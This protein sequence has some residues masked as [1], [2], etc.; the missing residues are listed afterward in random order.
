MS[1][2][3]VY[4]TE[5]EREEP[6]GQRSGPPPHMDLNTRLLAAL[7]DHV[8][9]EENVS[10]HLTAMHLEAK[11]AMKSASKQDETVV[12][13]TD[14][15]VI[16][17]AS[18][19]M[20]AFHMFT[21]PGYKRRDRITAFATAF[22][23]ILLQILAISAVAVGSMGF[24]A[25]R[26]DSDC[27]FEGMFC[28][29]VGGGLGKICMACW[30]NSDKSPHIPEPEWC[31]I[32][33]ES[34]AESNQQAR[35]IELC[36]LCYDDDLKVIHY[37]T[38]M[39]KNG[40]EQMMLGDWANLVIGAIV[41]GLTVVGEL[42]DILYL[43]CKLETAAA[44]TEGFDLWYPACLML[45]SVRLYIFLPILCCTV[46]W[47]VW[48]AGS[49]ALSIC[50]NTVAVGFLV[51]LD[52]MVF[53]SGLEETTKQ[54][55]TEEGAGVTIDSKSEECIVFAKRFLG[56][57]AV[58]LMVACTANEIL[59]T[60]AS[61]FIFAFFAVGGMI[62]E[63]KWERAYSEG[64]TVLSAVKRASLVFFG[65]VL[66]SLIACGLLNNFIFIQPGH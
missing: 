54:R 4:V 11:E 43:R 8:C 13:K 20:V 53:D 23:L 19:H 22:S 12:E 1:P 5:A 61:T 39:Y 29:S 17:P 49:D 3:T 25:C 37:S 14:A 30:D 2:A 26:E 31:S 36:D 47:L 40:V 52:N 66:P 34:N 24:S 33:N 18:Y 44:A 46:P 55:F 38:D 28:G 9:R 64:G 65:Q 16:E 51:D 6:T 45:I 32:R 63:V 59:W 48:S 41:V 56:I 35:K 21:H 42:R 60:N 27:A 57:C 58:V 15:I 50:M 62:I 7:L 10:E